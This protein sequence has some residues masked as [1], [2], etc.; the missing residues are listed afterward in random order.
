MSPNVSPRHVGRRL[1][2]PALAERGMRREAISPKKSPFSMR[3]R[4]FASFS[5]F[6]MATR[7]ADDVHVLAVVPLLE[8]HV[9]FLEV[10]EELGEG[11]L[12]G[13]HVRGGRSLA[14]DPHAGRVPPGAEAPSSAG[15]G[16]WR[17]DRF[18]TSR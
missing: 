11:I 14:Q 3:P 13:G 15:A 10:G 4:G 12:L 16:A 8:K 18:W 1:D 7:P 2:H 9:A 6:L 17:I 5:F